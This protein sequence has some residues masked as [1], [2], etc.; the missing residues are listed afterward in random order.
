MDNSIPRPVNLPLKQCKGCHLWLTRDNFGIDNGMRDGM[1]YKCKSCC[2]I[3]RKKY[4]DP[5]KAR[6]RRL[7]QYGI[8]PNEYNRML[9]EQGNVCAV[10]KRPETHIRNHLTKNTGETRLLSVDHDHKTGEARAILCSAC[11]VALGRMDE[12]PERIR[13]LADYA[14]WC[15][16]REPSKKIVQLPLLSDIDNAV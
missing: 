3:H 16:N 13:A 10:C 9:A 5:N 15:Q 2:A 7:R 11:N 14:E 1:F 6:T 4:Y 12:D 8:T